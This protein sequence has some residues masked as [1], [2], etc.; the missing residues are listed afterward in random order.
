MPIDFRY[1]GFRE[2]PAISRFLND[3]W[4]ADHVY[5]R[6]PRLFDWTFHRPGHWPEDQYSFA[7]AE[8]RGELVGILGGIPFA[9]NCYGRRSSGVW[10]ANYV[11]RPDHRRGPTA[12]QLLGQ[13]R[14]PE[15][16]ACVAFGITQASA[17][18]YRVMRGEVLEPI[19]RLFVLLP[20]N[21]D[22]MLRLLA[23]AHP[24]WPEERARG[25]AE[26][27][28]L[29]AVPGRA[30]A[31]GNAIPADWDRTDWPAI[32][33]A[34]AGAARD[35]DYL[36]WRYLDHPL[37]EYRVIAVGEGRRTGLA[38][39]R[40]ETIRRQAPEGRVDVDTIGRVVEFLPA[41]RANAGALAAV[42]L[43]ELCGA[44]AFAADFYGYHGQTRAWLA[45]AGFRSAAEHP[46]G[47]NIPSRF[48]PLDGK[49]GEILSAMF[50]DAP[51]PACSAAE[52]C[53]WYWTKSDSDQD[54]PN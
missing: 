22:R 7:L 36:R 51:L 2:Y 29:D 10:I 5:C 27:F 21:L 44:G 23:I 31:H 3:Y 34:T 54:R 40:L 24:D 1:A 14:R 37:F 9:F 8:D 43:Q 15:F 17:V 46:D 42:L 19:P 30:I 52:D 47:G 16:Q 32:A 33:S 35:F 45:E 12:L 28:L 39:W 50:V 53:R 20:G 25:L 6:E 41:S 11:I 4:A 38:V 49:S 26:H 18:I 48:Q 13:F